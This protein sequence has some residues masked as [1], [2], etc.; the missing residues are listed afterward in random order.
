MKRSP[1]S[2]KDGPEVARLQR[3]RL[4]AGGAATRAQ[5]GASAGSGGESGSDYP[6]G[7]LGMDRALVLLP[8][9]VGVRGPDTS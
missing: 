1:G 5:E 8:R 7:P 3:P 9:R 6:D 2:R 4:P